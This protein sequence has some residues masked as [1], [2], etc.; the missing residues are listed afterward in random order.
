MVDFL[1]PI[2]GPGASTQTDFAAANA[3][4]G[5]NFQ[6]LPASKA[7]PKPSWAWRHPITHP[8]VSVFKT[9]GSVML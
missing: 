7:D 9:E 6:G 4:T 1:Q 5:L 8:P 2:L 3:K